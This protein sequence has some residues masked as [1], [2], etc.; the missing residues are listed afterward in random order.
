MAI[1]VN[2]SLENHVSKTMDC[3]ME[4]VRKKIHRP[5]RRSS[6]S[7]QSTKQRTLTRAPVHW[8]SGSEGRGA[9]GKQHPP[10]LPGRC[11]TR[12]GS[13]GEQVD[14]RSAC[15][16]MNSLSTM[17][18][19]VPCARLPFQLSPW[20]EWADSMLCPPPRREVERSPAVRLVRGL[21]AR[22]RGRELSRGEKIRE[23]RLMPKKSTKTAQSGGAPTAAAPAS[24]AAR[25]AAMAESWMPTDAPYFRTASV[26]S[27]FAPDA[28]LATRAPRLWVCGRD[29][30]DFQ[31]RP[32]P[33]GPRPTCEV[34]AVP[35]ALRP[36]TVAQAA[37][38]QAARAPL[39]LFPARA[40]AA[41]VTCNTSR[42]AA[43]GRR[44]TIFHFK[45]CALCLYIPCNIASCHLVQS[46]AI[47]LCN[48]RQAGSI[49]A[50]DRS[51]KA[52]GAECWHKCA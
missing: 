47:T 52:S 18:A 22:A 8:L 20:C 7:T 10:T 39:L 51:A 45:P 46:H 19:A 5:P 24:R 38:S 3:Q 36:T 48:V 1:R 28:C 34:K 2:M 42:P 4:A 25:K 26:S 44:T 11:P 23:R 17:V 32:L 43:T 49:C 27:S 6:A 14:K 33:T 40:M 15:L 30:D 12:R 50:N 35:T 29:P 41:Q 37:S 31:W 13:G 16:D 21:F 9:E